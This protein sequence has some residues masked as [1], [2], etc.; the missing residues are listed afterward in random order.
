M[1]RYRKLR[2]VDVNVSSDEIEGGLGD[3]GEVEDVGESRQAGNVNSCLT[4]G[5]G[6]ERRGARTGVRRNM[7]ENVWWCVEAIN[8]I[9]W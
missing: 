3:E 9:M 2:G 6:C 4:C 7:I 8:A 1:K 5:T